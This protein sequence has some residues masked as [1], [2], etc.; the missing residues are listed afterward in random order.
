MLLTVQDAAREADLT[1]DAIR[2]AIQ[3]GRLPI[4]EMYGRMLIAR[5]AFEAYR[6]TARRGR[7]RKTDT[8]E[9]VGLEGG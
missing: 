8:G 9:A 1:E 7:P 6:K 3:R 4:V 2:K 5:E